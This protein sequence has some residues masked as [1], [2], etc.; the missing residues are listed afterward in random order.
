MNRLPGLCSEAVSERVSNTLGHGRIALLNDL[1]NICSKT[2]LKILSDNL[3][4]SKKKK[5]QT[6]AAC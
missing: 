1:L 3:K 6:T 5:V 2:G 4:Q